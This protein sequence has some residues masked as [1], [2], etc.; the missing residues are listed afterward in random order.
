M[1]LPNWGLTVKF[2]LGAGSGSRGFGPRWQTAR[3]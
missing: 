3:G 1:K 2:T